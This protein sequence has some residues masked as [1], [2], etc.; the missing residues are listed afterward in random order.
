MLGLA[1]FLP[2]TLLIVDE[3]LYVAQALAFADGSRTL[4]AAA[5]LY[6]PTDLT[7]A[8]NYPPLTSALQVPFVTMLGW[9]GA[10]VLSVLALIVATLLTA[11]LLRANGL[12]ERFA[13]LIPAFPSTLFFARTAMSDLP[14]LAWV[15][16]TLWLLWKAANAHRGFSCAA[17]LVAGLSALLREPLLVLLA[18]LFLGAI[19]RRKIHPAWVIIGGT[20][21]LATRPLVF[22]WMFGDPLYVRD[23]GYGFSLGAALNNWPETFIALGILVPAGFLLPFLYRGERKIEIATA[24]TVYSALFLFY[25][26]DPTRENG[27]LK[28]F[29]LFSRYFIPA[30]PLLAICAADVY[31]RAFSA[32]LVYFKKR[33]PVGTRLSAEPQSSAA[34]VSDKKRAPVGTRLLEGAVKVIPLGIAA[35]AF[36]I[37]PVVRRMEAAPA[38]VVQ[39]FQQNTAEQVPVITN[40]LATTKYLSPVYGPRRLIIRSAITGAEVPRFFKQYGPLTVAFLDRSDSDL[41][42]DDMAANAAFLEQAGRVCQLESRYD[43]DHPGI[44]RVRVWNVTR[45]AE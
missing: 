3:A 29:L 8:S 6:P 15:A 34:P 27:A 40:H 12:D 1:V 28:G 41:F 44:G 42:R 5:P 45:C 38:G 43:R 39:A 16:L 32:A 24:V 21:G 19:I 23:S 35:A 13:L 7:V 33:G 25:D 10:V 9:R 26:W 20:L 17:G 4:A 2:R 36:L 30:L 22:A 31:P 11:R 37:H 18:P 14:A